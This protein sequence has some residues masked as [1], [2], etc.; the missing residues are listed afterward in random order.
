MSD[1]TI[2]ASVVPFGKTYS[3]G[4]WE[5]EFECKQL[6]S[7]CGEEVET[8]INTNTHNFYGL[9]KTFP[10]TYKQKEEGGDMCQK[11]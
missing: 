2:V 7:L 9:K 10:I 6:E 4:K 1:L 3:I 5:M 11:P 8:I